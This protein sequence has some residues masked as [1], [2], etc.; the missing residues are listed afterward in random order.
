MAN[1]KEYKIVINGLEESI[2][3]VDSLNKQLDAL[4]KKINALQSKSVNIGVSSNANGNAKSSRANALSEEEKLL[5]QIEQTENK[6]KAYS[7]DV[8]RNYMSSKEELNKTLETQKQVAAQER[9]QANNYANTMKG[10]KQQLS[11]IKQVMQT[12]EI[13]SDIFKKY[14]AEANEIT[15]KLKELEEAYSQF[16]RNVGNYKSAADGFNKIK[17]AVGDT[18]REYD[19]YR[20]AIKALRGEQFQLSQTLGQESKEY[21]DIHNAIKQLESAYKDLSVSSKFMD[22]MLDSMSTMTAFANVGVGLSNFF[23]IDDAAFDDA[24]RKMVG[25]SQALQGL[26]VLR[27]QWQA[28]DSWLLKPFKAISGKVGELLTPLKENINSFFS[29]AFDSAFDMYAKHVKN[30]ALNKIFDDIGDLRDRLGKVFDEIGKDEAIER[31]VKKYKDGLDEIGLS[32][33][34]IDEQVKFFKDDLESMDADTLKSAFVDT[35]SMEEFDSKLT[36]T[37]KNLK[38]HLNKWVGYFKVFGRTVSMVLKSIFSAGFL[39]FLPEIINYV[40]DFVKSLDWTKRAAEQATDALNTLNRTFEKRLEMLGS[41]YMKGEISSEEYLEEVYKKQADAISKQI[42]LLKERAD[43]AKDNG[44][45]G[46]GWFTQSE[47]ADFSGNRMSGETTVK[48]GMF[49]QLEVTVK[50]ITEVEKAWRRA[51]QAIKDGKDYVDKWAE[52]DTWYQR[53]KKGWESIFATVGQTEDVLKGMGNIKLSDTIAQFQEVSDKLSEGKITTDQYAKELAKLRDAMNDNAI[54]NSVIANLD[55]YIPDE[56]VRKEIQ[57]II[58]KIYELDDAFNMTSPQQIHKW[59]QVRIDAMK[60]GFD[61]TMAQIKENERYEIEQE[62]KTDEQRKLIE[63][64][65]ERQRQD[66]RERAAK[67]NLQKAKEQGKKLTDAENQL[68]ALRIENMKNGLKKRLAELDNQKRLELQKVKDNGIMVGELTAEINKKYDKLVL[69]EKRKWAFDMLR[70]YEDLAERI[71]QLNKSTFDIEAST[72]TQNVETRERRQEQSAG[73]S[74]ITPSTYDDS[75][76]L[77]QYYAKVV[78]IKKEAAEK[79]LQIEKERLDKQLEFDKREEELRHKRLIDENGGEYI[80]QL[81]AGLITQEQ[82][83]KL[84]EDENDAHKARMNAIDKQYASNLSATTQDSLEKTQKLYSDY[85]GNIINNLRKDKSKVDEIMSKQPV[86]DKGGWG[87]VNIGATSENY[88]NALKQYDELKQEIVKKQSELKRDLESGHISAQDFALRQSELDQEMK[89]IDEASK[90]MVERQKQVFGEFIQSIQPYVQAAFQGIQQIMQAVWD[91]QDY[92]IDKELDELD[93]WNEELDKKLQEQ[94]DIVEKHKDNVESIEDELA[95]ARGDRRQHLIDQLN[96]EV[97]AQRAAQRE[98]QRIQREQEKA[99][100]REE[101]LEKKRREQEY[102]RN[103]MQAFISWHLAIANGLAT[104][105]F[106][107][108]GIAM[109]A[110]ATTL[111]AIQYAL[112]KSQKPY[113]I[114]GQLEGGLVK[115]KRHNADGSGGVP[116]GNTGIFVEGDEMIIRRESTMPNIDL[117]NYINN[118]KHKLSLDDFIDFYSNG[119]IKKNIIS[120]S[121]KTK[122]ADGG[123]LPSLNSDIDI[124]DR[125]ISAMEAYANRPYYVTVTDIENRMNQVKYV[126]TL[127]GVEQQ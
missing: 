2:N 53:L 46:T 85:Y 48:S 25:L 98:E 35:F 51:N 66:A 86:V 22:N 76:A 109:G 61:K 50:N 126:R 78:E 79:E 108:V 7:K 42:D 91:A 102:K 87:I 90:E 74:M 34:D 89:S 97:D 36:T 82:Y 8:Y 11:D 4:E 95:T 12:T 47:N 45:L 6:I 104:Q 115:G 37:G 21:K 44:V 113:R 88:S 30:S 96:A 81:R 57:N 29:N 17:V 54:L 93:K 70:T 106:L 55:K 107:P 23:G 99:K 27:Q 33:E 63:A 125:L 77:E 111:G 26:E 31:I 41:S 60:D 9:L 116:V 100:K 1:I 65:Y 112:V 92:Q 73:Y 24:M 120:M 56:E 80:Q 124:N 13:G 84:I 39:L 75:K 68:M 58:N 43:A 28:D 18:T 59:N 119:K 38:E 71:N 122:F 127:A 110:L 15:N 32:L 52:D 118:S 114:G 72:A 101:A 49:N 20:Q 69:D 10:L 67:E 117:L 123:I 94:Q 62:A 40:M 5:K 14:T 105:P 83:D 19:N 64:K 121:P 16:G 103:V 3:A